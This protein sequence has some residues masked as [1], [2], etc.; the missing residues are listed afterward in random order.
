MIFNYSEH[1]NLLKTCQQVLANDGYI[2]TTFSHHLPQHK[3]R[4]LKFF[5]IAVNMGF[6]VEELYN[7][8]VNVM[9]PEDEG[10][11]Y[12]RSTVFCYRLYLQNAQTDCSIIDPI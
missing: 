3:Q 7:E 12:D 4:D 9:F 11:V 8:R 10:D 2:L 6:F 5:E 1:Y